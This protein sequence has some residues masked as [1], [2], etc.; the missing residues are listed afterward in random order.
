M[1]YRIESDYKLSSDWIPENMFTKIHYD[2]SAAIATAIEGVDD[3]KNQEV[4]VIDVDTGE[5]VFK[6]TEEEYD[7]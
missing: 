5:I 7:D 6:S 4:R 1:G 3:P 2:R